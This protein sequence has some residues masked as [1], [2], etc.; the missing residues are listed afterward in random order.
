MPAIPPPSIATDVPLPTLDNQSPG[1]G[2]TIPSGGGGD[3]AGGLAGAPGAADDDP[4]AFNVVPIPIAA[5]V[6][7]IA[8]LPTARPIEVRKS[9]LAMVLFFV[10]IFSSAWCRLIHY[11]LLHSGS[12][13]K[14][15]L[16]FFDV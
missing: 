8:E 1:R 7:N 16:Y 9:R 15:N 4:Q 6:R 5:I 2:E 14:I 13:A 11:R 10:V 3:G 12:A